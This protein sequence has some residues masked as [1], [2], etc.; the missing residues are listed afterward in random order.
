MLKTYENWKI[1]SS[2]KKTNRFWTE[3]SAKKWFILD[4]IKKEKKV[5]LNPIE[6]K[7]QLKFMFVAPQFMMMPIRTCKKCSKF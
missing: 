6:P 3:I 5:Q 1:N 4:S 2:K 7:K